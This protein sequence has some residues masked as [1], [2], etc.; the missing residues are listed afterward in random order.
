VVGFTFFYEEPN[1]RM[2]TAL[3]GGLA[4]LIGFTLFIIMALDFPFATDL[5]ITPAAFNHIL[6][7][8]SSIH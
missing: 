8:G 1:L 4:A 5:S 7:E 3:T 6:D 2:Q